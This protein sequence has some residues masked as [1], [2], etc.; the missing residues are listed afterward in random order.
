MAEEDLVVSLRLCKAQARPKS[1]QDSSPDYDQPI[2]FK[3]IPGA[4]WFLACYVRDVFNRLEAIKANLTSATGRI[5]K[6][7]GTK[8]ILN[9]LQGHAADSANWVVNVG[10]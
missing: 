8:K 10:N 6:I 1:P 3:E 7:D 4:S 5:L 9:K 2:S